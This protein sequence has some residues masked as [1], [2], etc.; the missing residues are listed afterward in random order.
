MEND[1]AFWLCRFLCCGFGMMGFCKGVLL[2]VFF[3][4]NLEKYGRKKKRVMV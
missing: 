2:V 1:R 4:K 3:G